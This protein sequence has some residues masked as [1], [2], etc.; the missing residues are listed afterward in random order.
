LHDSEIC[1][2]GSSSCL[3]FE[4][5]VFSHVARWLKS[6]SEVEP[7]STGSFDDDYSQEIDGKPYPDST[8]SFTQKLSKNSK[9]RIGG[10]CNHLLGTAFRRATSKSTRKVSVRSS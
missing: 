6:G 3:Q 9:P 4:D 8:F 2:W 5:D 10:I 1:G 7:S